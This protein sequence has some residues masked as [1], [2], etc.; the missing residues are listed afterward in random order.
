MMK[1]SELLVVVDSVEEAVKFYTEKLAFDLVDTQVSVENSNHLVSAQVKKGKCCIIFRA[2]HVEELADFSFI[3][4]CSSRCAGLYVEMKKGLDRY[5][6]R[7]IK[8]G[9]KI[10]SEPKMVDG[11]RTF[12]LKD[13]FGIKLVIA[14]VPEKAAVASSQFAGLSLPISAIVSKARKESD[15]VDEMVSHLRKFGIL[16]RASKKYAKA[17]LKAALKKNKS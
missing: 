6:D 9:V 16:R 15:I 10:V 2:P 3:K 1:S 14:E 8:K 4:R 13:P 7:C 17:H 5:F 11:H 12:V